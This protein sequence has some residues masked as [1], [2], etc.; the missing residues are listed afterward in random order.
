MVSLLWECEFPHAPPKR[1]R[2]FP[3]Y[4]WV[5]WE[6]VTYGPPMSFDIKPMARILRDPGIDPEPSTPLGTT[7]DLEADTVQGQIEV[8]D[9][10]IHRGPISPPTQPNSR[11]LY[12][13]FC[14]MNWEKSGQGHLRSVDIILPR[15][16]L[17][18]HKLSGGQIFFVDCVIMGYWINKADIYHLSLML[19]EYHGAIAERVGIMNRCRLS[20]E[21]SRTLPKMRRRIRLG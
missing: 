5:G 18:R 16:F 21:L 4:S 13:S 17:S 2:G 20:E 14:L 8:S 12:T 11:G 10:P 19:I 7:L 9:K 15:D 1:R 3:S 6:G